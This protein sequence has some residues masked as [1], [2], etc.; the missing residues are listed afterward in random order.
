MTMLTVVL[1][2]NVVL[3]SNYADRPGYNADILPQNTPIR[4]GIFDEDIKEVEIDGKS[5]VGFW[6]KEDDTYRFSIKG[7]TSYS[8]YTDIYVIDENNELKKP[9]R[10]DNN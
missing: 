1:P 2:T 3:G 6:I 9:E 8:H 4:R 7:N 10:Y 5:Y